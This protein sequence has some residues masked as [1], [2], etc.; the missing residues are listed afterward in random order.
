[1]M[2]YKARL[3]PARQPIRASW[4]TSSTNNVLRFS[5][6]LLSKRCTVSQMFRCRVF[7][8]SAQ[9]AVA[10]L[11]HSIQ[12]SDYWAWHT[13]T[14]ISDFTDAK[15]DKARASPWSDS[16][17]EIMPLV[18]PVCMLSWCACD[19][20]WMPAPAKEKLTH[21]VWSTIVPLITKLLDKWTAITKWTLRLPRTQSI[22]VR[23]HHVDQ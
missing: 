10:P 3:L 9:C 8:L 6:P 14:K 18:W 4:R 1:M 20:F 17:T 12:R 5:W 23:S 13:I 22:V 2:S 16:S 15:A 19:W 11:C 21:M 7:E